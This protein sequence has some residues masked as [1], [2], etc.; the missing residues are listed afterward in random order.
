MWLCI[1]RTYKT[2]RISVLFFIAIKRIN[3]EAEGILAELKI[4][5]KAE[6]YL[7][8]EVVWN[9]SI[10]LFTRWGYRLFRHFTSK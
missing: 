3:Q 9:L 1:C 2:T 10:G 8:R 6:Q 5:N 4:Y 7:S